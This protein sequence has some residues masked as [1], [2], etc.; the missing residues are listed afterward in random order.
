MKKPKP[1]E[2]PLADQ[3]S[4][5]C[6]GLNPDTKKWSQ[7]EQAAFNKLYTRLSEIDEEDDSCRF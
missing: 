5:L 4:A 1:A 7:I 6:Q 3:L 2:L